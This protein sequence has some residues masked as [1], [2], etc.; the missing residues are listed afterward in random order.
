[1]LLINTDYY[2]LPRLWQTCNIQYNVYSSPTV[3]LTT[4]LTQLLL[5]CSVK[6]T[7]CNTS[8]TVLTHTHTQTLFNLTIH[9]HICG[10]VHTL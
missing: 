2:I 10:A 1:M 7:E 9:T 6:I 8:G 3:H 4:T 5:V